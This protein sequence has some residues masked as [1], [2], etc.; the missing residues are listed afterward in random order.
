M[1]QVGLV[2]DNLPIS[3][4]ALNTLPVLSH[5]DVLT[6]L[7]VLPNMGKLSVVFLKAEQHKIENLVQQI[8]N[9][10]IFSVK[11]RAE[12]DSGSF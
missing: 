9:Y 5:L 3:S 7:D 11:Y 4:V 1:K 8:D 6:E 10:R 12:M 2:I